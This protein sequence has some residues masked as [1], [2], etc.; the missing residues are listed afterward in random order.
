VAPAPLLHWLAYVLLLLQSLLSCTAVLYAEQLRPSA[1]S[2]LEWQQVV[3]AASVALSTLCLAA[4]AL[5]ACLRSGRDATAPP[6]A[7]ASAAQHAV[8]APPD[9]REAGAA[10]QDLSG[11]WVKDGGASDSME[12]ACDAMRLGGLVRTAIRRAAAGG[13]KHRASFLPPSLHVPPR[14]CCACVLVPP[15]PSCPLLPGHAPLQ[16]GAGLSPSSLLL[17]PVLLAMPA[18]GSSRAWRCGLTGSSSR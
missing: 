18:A 16:P 15:R 5:A 6:P 14:P 4:A 3:A 2:P 9:L 17:P 10:P 13:R 7:A 1:F 8:V 12:P 11:V